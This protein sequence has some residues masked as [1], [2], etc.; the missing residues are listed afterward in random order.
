MLMQQR[1]VAA[2]VALWVLQLAANFAERLS[3]PR[4]LDWGQAP[5]RMS[6]DATVGRMLRKRE[7][8]VRVAR[9]AGISWH[10][11]TVVASR[12]LRPM[13]MHV[14]ALCRPVAGRMA[15]HAARAHDHPAR[16]GK[17]GA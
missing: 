8:M 7:V 3:L 12:N 17:E 16:L 10:A 9:A 15:V 4:H 6:G 13:R 1:E 2:T 14:I 5:A 11:D